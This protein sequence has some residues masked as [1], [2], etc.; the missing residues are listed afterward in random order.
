MRQAKKEIR[1]RDVIVEVLNACHVGRL[2][3]AGKDGYP[4]VK[5]LNFAYHDAKIYFHTAKDGEKIEDIKRDDR[6]CFEADL[7]IALVKSRESP[8][9]AE[10]LYRSVI[11]RGRARIVEDG[12]E[13][14]LALK[15]LMGK[16]Q[17]EGGYGE[18]AVE[19]LNNTGVV[20][21]DIEEMTGKE[22][23]GKEHL[24]DAALK[25][26]ENKVSLPIVLERT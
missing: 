19:K 14:L 6:V 11:I 16:Y 26:L 12:P 17:P 4:M 3:T 24:R 18:F 7:P 21:I 23:L 15:L 8:C 20:R 1:Q 10:Y 22:D 13:K 2:G 9:R 5:P 25:A